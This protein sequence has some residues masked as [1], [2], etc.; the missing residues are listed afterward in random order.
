MIIL[1][2]LECDYDIK[3]KVK[4]NKNYFQLQLLNENNINN[5]T[6]KFQSIFSNII[7][8]KNIIYYY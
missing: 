3:S 5:I 4:Y 7:I 6:I 1:Q 8:K 2:F